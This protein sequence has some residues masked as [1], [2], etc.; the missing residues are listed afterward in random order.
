VTKH[1]KKIEERDTLLFAPLFNKKGKYH[2]VLSL[3]FFPHDMIGNHFLCSERKN[4]NFFFCL[5]L[6]KQN[7]EKTV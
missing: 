4:W 5:S 3:S 6:A 1:C 2:T 7:K